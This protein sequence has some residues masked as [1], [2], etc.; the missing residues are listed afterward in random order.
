MEN[1][2][3]K[4]QF[5]RFSADLPADVKKALWD[6]LQCPHFNRKLTPKDGK[7]SIEVD[8]GTACIRYLTLYDVSG[9]P[10]GADELT[11][12]SLIQ[13]RG[14]YRL[15]G[16]AEDYFNEETKLFTIRFSR[17]EVDTQACRVQS[18]LPNC[19][20]WETLLSMAH[21]LMVK[22]SISESL[23][24]HAE[25]AMRPLL[26]ELARLFTYLPQPEG[27]TGT[28]F[29]QLRKIIEGY[30]ATELLPILDKLE[31]SAHPRQKD[32]YLRKLIVKLDTVRYEPLFRNIWDQLVETQRDYPTGTQILLEE[33]ERTNLHNRIQHMMEQ[34]GYSG[35]YP[36][37]Y[38]NTS[39]KGLRLAESYGMDYFVMGEKNT[40]SHI[41][42]NEVANE[43][44]CLELICGTQLLKKDQHRGDYLTCT[45]N[46]KGRTFAKT[47]LCEV[48]H[49]GIILPVADK[50]AQLQRLNKEERKLH[51]AEKPSSLSVFFACLILGGGGFA[52][53]GTAAM[54]L[55]GAVTLLLTGDLHLLPE[56]PWLQM[57]AF[58]WLGYGGLMGIA[59]SLI[60][61]FK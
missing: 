25:R 60:N 5:E 51:S 26:E 27:C 59:M 47:I 14:E 55:I 43:Q 45:F 10:E 17:A 20:P 39:I 61:R 12:E 54:L 41:H 16:E 33:S 35:S 2:I 6:L 8:S 29:T 4:E 22:Y 40:V 31:Q 18:I 24:N 34:L 48:N 56:F 15:V 21:Q 9:V 3:Q 44:V 32:R 58:A 1:N 23:F 57:F 50:L 53:L 30:G 36:D 28:T 37:Y 46:S 49:L 11:F 19:N 42:V 38:K 7:L 52:V 13:R